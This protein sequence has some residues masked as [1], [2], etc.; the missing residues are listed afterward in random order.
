MFAIRGKTVVLIQL[1]LAGLSVGAGGRRVLR[2]LPLCLIASIIGATASIAASSEVFSGSNQNF[3]ASV[4]FELLGGGLLQVSLTNTFTGDTPDQAHVLTGVFFSGADGL[5]PISATAAAGSKQWSGTSFSVPFSSSVLGTEWA[6]ATSPGPG[7]STAGIVSAGFWTPGFGNFSPPG[8][9]LDGSAYGLL[10]AGYAGSDLDGLQ[11]RIYIQ[12][13]MIF[14]LSG[15]SG[16]LLSIGN[17]SFQYGTALSEP[18]LPALPATSPVPE[19]GS[20]ALLGFGLAGFL[21]YRQFKR[22][23]VRA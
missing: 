8:D 15:F 21:V 14:V 13:T 11:N 4:G 22:T 17:V 23:G 19:P 12:N 18:S 10:S 9:M 3:S 20:I 16:S 6:Y 5:N 7:G 2:K 1:A